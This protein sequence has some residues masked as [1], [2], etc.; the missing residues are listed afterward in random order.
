[1][2]GQFWEHLSLAPFWTFRLCWGRFLRVVNLTVLLIMVL[3]F[4]QD[5]RGLNYRRIFMCG[6]IVHTFGLS[7]VVI[8]L[9]HRGG[10]RLHSAVPYWRDIC[11]SRLASRS[12]HVSL[13][14]LASRSQH[15]S[16][17]RLASH[18]QH[19]SLS[20]LA[21]RSQRVRLGRLMDG[22][23]TSAPRQDI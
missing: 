14:R 21:S 2:D 15:V 19:V 1:M 12:H 17:S 7:I 18:S 5:T 23:G 20:R 9:R 10:I 13:S 11:M 16:L 3:H 6:Y 4:N 22:V 8:C